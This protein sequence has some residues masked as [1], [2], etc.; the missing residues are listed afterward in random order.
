MKT[1]K[2]V[3]DTELGLVLATADYNATSESIFKALTEAGEIE[4]WWGSAETYHMRNWVADLR[5]GGNYTVNVVLASG[6]VYP[7]SGRFIEIAAPSR[8]S[9]TR[10]YDWD[11]PTI[12]RRETIITY[13]IETIDG[14]TR[15][16][17]RHEGFAGA[18]AAAIEHAGGWERVM[19]WLGDYVEK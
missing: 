14:G 10:R 7:A 3:A 16:N 4:Y 6:G 11:H 17:V 13:R 12:G 8:L 19:A 15:L 9:H 5:P 2:A 1:P 18:P